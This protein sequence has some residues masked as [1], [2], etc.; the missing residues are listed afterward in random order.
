MLSRAISLTTTSPE[1]LS[2]QEKRLEHQTD[3]SARNKFRFMGRRLSLAGN[4]NLEH[5]KDALFTALLF[6][7]KWIFLFTKKKTIA[8]RNDDRI[9]LGIGRRMRVTNISLFNLGKK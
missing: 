4:E 9:S 8:S 1:V 3:V 5:R 2:R 6:R 7:N